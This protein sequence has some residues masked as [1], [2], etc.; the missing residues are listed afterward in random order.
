[1]PD[2]LY[3]AGRHL[4][5]VLFIDMVGFSRHMQQSETRTI[6]QVDELFSLIRQAAAE[7]AGREI[8]SAGDG[9]LLE[10]SGALRAV[11]CALQVH[12]ALAKRNRQIS[13]GQ[14]KIHARA[15]VHL[16]E[17]EH[18]EG[19]I[20]G[21]GVNIG[22][23]LLPLAPPAGIAISPHVKDQLANVLDQPIA[24][25]GRKSLKNIREPMEVFC[26]AGA[27]CRQQDINACTGDELAPQSGR[28]WTLGDTL[29]DERSMTLTVDGEP[30]ALERK[31]LEVLLMLLRHA[32]EVV[33]KDEL[34]EA[35]WPGRV[36]SE[37]SLNK[38]ISRIRTVLKDR[39]QSIIV[40]QRGY[41]YRLAAHV[42]VEASEAELTPQLN[43]QPGDRL[44]TRPNW[45]LVQQIG[46]GGHGEVWLARHDKTREER[47]FKLALEAGHLASLKREITLCRLLHDA[48]PGNEKFVRVL[49][50][51]LEREP[52]FVESEYS[53]D[54]SLIDWAGEQGGLDAVP[55]DTRLEI[56]AQV[57]EALSL[58]HDVG[59]LHKDLKPG[60][61]LIQSHPD[62]G[63]EI[64]LADFGSGGVIDTERCDQLSITR[65][66]F[67]QTSA[68][69]SDPSSTTPL[70]LAPEILAGH[71]AS[72]R[73]DIY[74]LGV[75]LYQLIVG[76]LR[77]ML[78]PGWEQSIADPLLREDIAL[79]AHGEPTQ[80]IATAAELASRLRHLD[81]RRQDREREAQ[82]QAARHQ[83]LELKRQNRRMRRVIAVVC[84]F[85]VLSLGL[86]GFAVHSRH[87]AL[88]ARDAAEDLARFLTQDMLSDL[89]I[90]SRDMRQLHLVDWLDHV[91]RQVPEQLSDTP[92]VA[93]RLYLALGDAFDSIGQGARAIVVGKQAVELAV[94]VWP[95][96]PEPGLALARHA[97][98]SLVGLV[99]KED[100]AFWEDLLSVA[101]HR[102][103]ETDRLS[104]R[105]RLHMLQ[106]LHRYKHAFD[107]IGQARDL[108][109]QVRQ[110]H[111]DDPALLK[112]ATRQLADALIISP[113]TADE[114][115]ALLDEHF[116]LMSAE[117]AARLSTLVLRSQ[118][119]ATLLFYGRGDK[120]GAQA[121]LKDAIETLKTR[122]HKDSSF[123]ADVEFQLLIL[124]TSLAFS[125]Q[126]PLPDYIAQLQAHDAKAQ[127]IFAGADENLLATSRFL[128]WAYL[129]NGEAEK[130]AFYARRLLDIAQR[131]READS[132]SIAW[133]RFLVASCDRRLGAL[134]PARMA[135]DSL[136]ASSS[137]SR[138]SSDVRV[139][140]EEALL[141]AAEGRATEAAGLLSAALEQMQA[142]LG[143]EHL[144]TQTTVADLA[145]LQN[146]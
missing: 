70:Y 29:V 102:W 23:R 136:R 18:R 53:R 3:D 51:N 127:R 86:G 93:I 110:H 116:A 111:A 98:A 24:S 5:A 133:A 130:A 1:M 118:A 131:H 75:M 125:G 103:G 96:D 132:F 121:L 105:F 17:L 50:W 56:A 134:E 41:G 13:N 107:D 11:Q 58:A 67:T 95:Q 72:A 81:Q 6:A 141:L 122:G 144:L 142:K 123:L 139:Q 28:R 31:P 87:L 15:S 64:R 101:A 82:E 65:L 117:E 34:L 19:H 8:D 145:A 42:C 12:G 21:D 126:T 66:G 36:L 69:G 80:R 128:A 43:L 2:Q 91:A 135:F 40:T 10:F 78:A 76:D 129:L 60:N 22:A 119:Y 46:S 26:I 54:G 100:L 49:D 143:A 84:A 88:E 55:L 32:G 25:L 99:R 57:A 92:E 30:T 89:N 68:L 79:A 94:Q 7:L 109:R 9:M 47:V 120:A 71:S 48:Y 114:V 44:E 62:R 61:V 37:S 113:D 39:D 33:T 77:R 137:W 14:Q 97:G 124:R 52:F 73:A 83:A 104:L 90:D 20:F 74:A 45:Q 106:P 115:E 59:V 35:V 85:L 140:R 27:D 138:L 112:L 38:A 146:R 16:G 108:L 4:A 63:I